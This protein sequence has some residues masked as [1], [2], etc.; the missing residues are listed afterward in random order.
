MG[1]PIDL[2]G[3]ELIEGGSLRGE[4]GVALDRPSREIERLIR[5]VLVHIV[6]HPRDGAWRRLFK[7]PRDGRFWERFYPHGE[8]HGGGPSSLKLV[9]P[10]EVRSEFGICE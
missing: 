3:I 8:L 2:S 4:N 9:R 6:D 1:K 7:D 10:D 5:E